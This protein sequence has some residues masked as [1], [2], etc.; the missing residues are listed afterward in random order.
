MGA[1]AFEEVSNGPDA[2]AALDTL[3]RQRAARFREM[4]VFDP[5]AVPAIRKF[6]DSLVADG[7]GVR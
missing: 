5:F 1:V 6:Y 2:L 4:G 3:F 7:S